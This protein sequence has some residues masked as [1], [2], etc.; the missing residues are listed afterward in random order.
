MITWLQHNHKHHRIG[1]DLALMRPI[2]VI[3]YRPNVS[4]SDVLDD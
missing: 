1:D 3:S 2:V 4:V